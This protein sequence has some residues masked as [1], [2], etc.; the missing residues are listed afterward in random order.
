MKIKRAGSK[1]P[2]TMEEIEKLQ[3][4]RC[5]KPAVFQWNACADENLYRPL[6]PPCDITLNQLILKYMRDPKWEKKLFRYQ[7]KVYRWLKQGVV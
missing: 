7:R 1:E 4:V 6:C 3:C 2:Y 5:G